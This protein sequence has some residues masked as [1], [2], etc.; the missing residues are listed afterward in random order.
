MFA[1]E[2][3]IDW[4]KVR[5]DWYGIYFEQGGYSWT[6]L[7][8]ED[9]E[10]TNEW[11]HGRVVSP[12]YA[13]KRIITFEWIID[14]ETDKM[15]EALRYLQRMFAISLDENKELIIVDEFN[16]ERKIDCKVVEPLI[17]ED[18]TD[19]MS[20]TAYRWRVVLESTSTPLL[21]SAI[22]NV[23][24]GVEFEFA[25]NYLNPTN[26]IPNKLNQWY[27]FINVEENWNQPVYPIIEIEA[28]DTIDSFLKVHNYTEK[29][30]FILDTTGQ[31]WDKIIID[32]D[33]QTVTKNGEDIIVDRREWSVRPKIVWQIKFWVF[34]WDSD[35]NS[36]D[37]NITFRF[38]DKLI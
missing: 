14:R 10:T 34:D 15:E 3:K 9:D 7:D 6:E 13:R 37:I 2:F 12:T 23:A 5:K 38:S 4:Q 27:N 35:I 36:S 26:K 33:E 20:G 24:V 17:T 22:E 8:V 16:N 1:N 31:P 29:N 25:G 18:Y 30:D 21:T 28:K 32:S 19:D 11:Y